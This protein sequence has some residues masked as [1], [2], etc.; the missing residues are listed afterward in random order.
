MEDGDCIREEN[1]SDAE[2]TTVIR[3][4]QEIKLQNIRERGIRT[5]KVKLNL[6]KNNF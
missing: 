3:L 6:G 4:S 5:L 2:S 1:G